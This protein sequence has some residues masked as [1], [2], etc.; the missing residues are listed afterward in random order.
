[1]MMEDKSK[2]RRFD[3]DP[4]GRR[5]ILAGLVPT[6]NRTDIMLFDD[7]EGDSD[8][9]E[10]FE[11]VDHP[12]VPTF[13]ASL[14]AI[15]S[16]PEFLTVDHQVWEDTGLGIT[17][18]QA[19]HCTVHTELLWSEEDKFKIDTGRMKEIDYYNFM[20][21]SECLPAIIDSTNINL[22]SQNLPPANLAEL[23]RMFG[24]RL[25]M[26]LDLQRGAVGDFWS[27]VQDP[28]SISRPPRYGERFGMTKARWDQLTSLWSLEQGH[29][30]HIAPQGTLHGVL[31]FIQAFNARRERCVRPGSL[32]CV[33]ESFTN[34]SGWQREQ[35][36]SWVFPQPSNWATLDFFKDTQ[37]KSCVDANTGIMLRLEFIE[38]EHVM[39]QKPYRTAPH[40]YSPATALVMRL[41]EPWHG[42]E[43]RIVAVNRAFSS[44]ECLQACETVGLKY[45]GGIK[46]HSLK[47]PITYL[48]KFGDQLGREGRG[49]IK[50]LASP[51]RLP[52]DPADYPNRQMHAVWWKGKRSVAL[53][54]N[55]S[56]TEPVH[57][58]MPMNGYG[59]VAT[60]AHPKCMDIY[61]KGVTAV[62]V[63]DYYREGKLGIERSFKAQQNGWQQIFASVWGMIIVDAFFAMRA[64]KMDF[65]HQDPEQIAQDL[66]AFCS[67]LAF[68]LIHSAEDE[69]AALLPHP[70]MLQSSCDDHRLVSV[71]VAIHQ[72][73]ADHTHKDWQLKCKICGGKTR[74]FCLKCSS[75][76]GKKLFGICSDST[77]KLKAC[78]ATHKTA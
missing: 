36:Q 48:E 31:A 4:T 56:T 10:F 62:N 37:L 69:G 17:V 18:D 51:Y 5:R 29:P 46:K 27:I 25:A 35:L 47:Y 41:T 8:G 1:M 6:S 22:T 38:S 78:F 73:A 7:E 9:A 43:P 54:A 68:Q 2:K 57:L 45:L 21:P 20:F 16:F 74:K 52:A 75:I 70:S 60:L 40:N 3:D 26:A 14:P 32:L 44:V 58:T 19:A 39:N 76:E 59:D 65:S 34:W 67:R 49:A 71:Q 42:K 23:K 64:A 13:P 28:G 33:S 55:A 24:I 12:A 53:L 30:S 77:T 61:F 15:P 63:H 66:M 50:V 11:D 72:L